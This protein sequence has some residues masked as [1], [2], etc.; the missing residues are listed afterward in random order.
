MLIKVISRKLVQLVGYGNDNKDHSR[1]NSIPRLPPPVYIKTQRN[2]ISMPLCWTAV[3]SDY[4]KHI[5]NSLEVSVFKSK[6]FVI[7]KPV[8]IGGIRYSGHVYRT[9]AYGGWWAS[10][11]DSQITFAFNIMP[12]EEHRLHSTRSVGLITRQSPT[13]GEVEAWMD[14]CFKKRVS[15]QLKTLYFRK[16]DVRIIAVHVPLGRH[17]LNVRITKGGDVPLTGIVIGPP[18]GPY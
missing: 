12:T 18:D 9:D 17:T 5:H 1:K 7:M 11:K 2:I 13:G 14:D 6:G 15:I 8:L 10:K 3:L 4:N 16:T